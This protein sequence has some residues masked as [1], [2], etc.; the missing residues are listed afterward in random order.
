MPG[1]ELVGL[2]PYPCPPAASESMIIIRSLGKAGANTRVS[3]VCGLN[4]SVVTSSIY[5]SISDPEAYLSSLW[6]HRRSASTINLP[7]KR[8]DDG[9]PCCSYD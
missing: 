2:T 6:R 7:Y 9:I 4:V 1:D 8:Q 3:L 5:C